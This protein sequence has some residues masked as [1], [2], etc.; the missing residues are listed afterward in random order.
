MSCVRVSPSH[1]REAPRIGI[2]ERSPQSSRQVRTNSECR[3]HVCHDGCVTAYPGWSPAP[4]PGPGAAWRPAPAVGIVPLHPYGFGTILGRSFQALRQN[5]GVL[6][7]FALCVQAVAYLVV[8]A[9]IGVV[10]F[11]SFSRLDTLTPGSDEW[12]A[13]SAGSIALTVVVGVVLSLASGALGVIIQGIVVTQVSAAVVAEKQTLRTLWRRVRPAAWRLIGYSFAVLLLVALVV[14]VV[15]GAIVALGFAVLPLAIVLGILV[16]LAAIPLWVWLST[17]LV[18][19]PAVLI[20]EGATIPAAIARSWRLTRRRFWS[21]FGVI[22][23]I[24]M[25]FSVLSQIVGVPLQFVAMALGQVFSPTGDP[26]VGGLIAILVVAGLTQVLQILIQCVALIVQSTA[27]ALIYVD[28][29]MRHEG[30]DHDLQTY[31]E[32]RDAGAEDL[33]DPYRAHIGRT[34]APMPWAAAP[35]PGPYAPPPPGGYPT[36][37]PAPA[38]APAYA[39]PVPQVPVPQAPPAAPPAPPAST[40]WTAPGGSS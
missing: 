14:G 5:P 7:G 13:V 22:V 29:R 40:Q 32:R 9:V 10:A 31:V 24:S 11:A 37:Y 36:A 28:C 18:L 33:A 6:L 21:T 23:I 20:L 34:V 26:D 30:L 35:P 3:S 16:V 8:I 15:G 4:A 25:S 19:V 17:K 38:Y 1:R 2:R 12:D 27:S 39:P